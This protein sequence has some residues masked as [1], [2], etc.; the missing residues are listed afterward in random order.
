VGLDEYIAHFGYAPMLPVFMP[1]LPSIASQA[2]A[3]AAAPPE[4]VV[5]PK[6]R[7]QASTKSL[8]ERKPRE[9]AGSLMRGSGRDRLFQEVVARPGLTAGDLREAVPL[10]ASPR[11]LRRALSHLVVQGF[12]CRKPHP[13][14][15]ARIPTYHPAK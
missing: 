13:L 5:D 2:A 8:A 9:K 7:K 4:P 3:A 1:E 10:S 12:L 15:G 11:A 6:R 14:L